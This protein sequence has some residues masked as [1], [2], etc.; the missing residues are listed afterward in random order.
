MSTL[1]R[2]SR[3]F[4]K[5]PLRFTRREFMK[6]LGAASAAV[7][8]A[9]MLPGCGNSVVSAQA[10]P[11]AGTVEFRHGVASGDPLVNRVI[12]WTRVTPCEG[13]NSLNV[14]WLIATD[15]LLASVIGAGTFLTNAARDFTVK[16]DAAGL[17]GYTTYY[18]QFRVG[19][20]K[21]PVGRTKTA[22]SAT[23]TERLRMAAVACSQWTTGYFNGYGN[24]ARRQDLDLVLCLG[25]YIYEYG[26]GEGDVRLHSPAH[27]IT[28]LSDYRER[29]AQYKTDPDLQELHRQNPWVTIWDD[30]E[31]ANNSYS[32]GAENHT[33]GAEG[34]WD[35]RKGWATRAYFEWMPIRDNAAT[36][37]DSPSADGLAPDGNGRSYR[38]LRYGAMVDLI[39]LDTRLAG[40]ALQAGTGIVSAEQTILGAT[41]REWFL[42]QLTG[43]QATWKIVPQQMTFAPLFIQPNTPA[44][45]GTYLN[46]DA[47]DGYRFD[48]DAFFDTVETNSIENVV[49][50]S[51]DIHATIACDLPRDP[52]PPNYD[53][54]TGAGSLGVELCSSG[55]AQVPLPIWTGLR[56]NNPHLL[57]TNEEQLG[58]LLM[59]I[60][61]ARV[62]AEWY[63]GAPVQQ[64]STQETPDPVMLACAAGTQHLAQ[65]TARTGSKPNPQPFAP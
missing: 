3:R 2:L 27:E 6:R 64:R 7:T 9:P 53:P 17:N 29:H 32:G 4:I 55:I 22:P 48:R 5:V 38:T 26:N 44:A 36:G 35:Q 10:L 19:D 45:P 30:H 8:V 31:S 20:T 1:A 11:V 16:V 34:V 51:G 57:H 58:Y 49:I 39:M 59:D 60:T 40:R 65:V 56:P 18:Y 41:Q 25:D 43:S 54:T 42:A 14:D 15:P 37:L 12:L 13:V 21:S 63:Y 24:L 33:E 52:S 50:L 47:W 23:E 61:P 28:T 62:Q 46:E